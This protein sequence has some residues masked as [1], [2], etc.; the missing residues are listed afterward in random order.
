MLR[1]SRH[2]EQGF[3]SLGNRIVD[4][5]AFRES[6]QRNEPLFR[7]LFRLGVLMAL[8]CIYIAVRD[9]PETNLYNLD[10]TPSSIRSEVSNVAE[11]VDALRDALLFLGG[12]TLLPPAGV[13][14]VSERE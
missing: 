5:E 9:I 13:R 10:N 6:L 7:N 12:E 14:H 4:F 3:V 11:R 8:T 1:A 2:Y